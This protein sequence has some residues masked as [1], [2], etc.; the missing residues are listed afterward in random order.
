MA[1][2]NLERFVDAQ[3]I[4]Y[5][6]ALEEIQRG[7]KQSHWMWYIFPQLEGLGRSSTARFYGIK[8]ISEAK[9]YLLHTILG[10][11]LIKITA[12]ALKHSDKSAHEIF[13]SPDDLKFHSCMTLF[14][15]TVKRIPSDFTTDDFQVFETAIRRFFGSKP[16]I[17]TVELL[18]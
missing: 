14:S 15:E 1:D 13:A 16:D 11:R 10:T 17:L 9:A 5:S 2:S 3:K 12:E 6:T 18:Q 8:D 4:S 7:R